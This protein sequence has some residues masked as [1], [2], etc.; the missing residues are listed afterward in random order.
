MSVKGPGYSSLY[1]IKEM[2]YAFR[3]S[4]ATYTPEQY[5]DLNGKLAVVTGANTGIGFQVMKLLYSKNCNVLCIVRSQEKGVA[6]RKRVLD[7]VKDSSGSIQVVGGCEMGSLEKVKT[8]S[9]DIAKAINGRPICLIVHNAGI[10]PSANTA[11]SE[12]GFENIFAVNVMGPQLLQHYLDPLFLKKDDDMKRIVWVSSSAHFYGFSDYGI[13]WENPTFEHVE[14]KDRPSATTLYGQSK[15]ANIFQAKAWATK[16]K[17]IV[18]KIGCVSVSC[19]PGL[20]QTDLQRDITSPLARKLISC[21]F[22]ESHYGAYSELFAALSPELKSTDQGAY[23]VPFGEVHDPRCDIKVG[24]ENGID[25]KLWDFVE[26]KI[27]S[28]F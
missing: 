4:S 8:A 21:M 25:L 6:A 24:L 28:F 17:E 5:P 10:M 23:I 12:D 2:Y 27:S 11:T 1:K 26:S 22:F 18:D 16:H 20:I 7:E 13:N 14:I 15:A 9:N 19:F 3:P